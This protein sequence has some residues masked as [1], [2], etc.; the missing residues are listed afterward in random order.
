MS[1]ADAFGGRPL[2]SLLSFDFALFAD[3]AR[4]GVLGDRS[5]EAF[6]TLPGITAQ[7]IR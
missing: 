6:F 7:L 5:S 4:F 1:R 3:H 2:N